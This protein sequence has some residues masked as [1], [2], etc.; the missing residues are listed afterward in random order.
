[1]ENPINRIYQDY[2]HNSQKPTG[3]NGVPNPIIDG[4][5]EEDFTKVR[6]CPQCGSLN[7]SF[8]MSTNKTECNDCHGTTEKPNRVDFQKQIE[9]IHEEEMKKLEDAY[10]QGTQII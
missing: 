4:E 7:I 5:H 8:D 6:S 9:D 1:M 2:K 3:T 10:K